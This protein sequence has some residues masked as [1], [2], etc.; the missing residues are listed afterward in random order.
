M[1]CRWHRQLCCLK[2]EVRLSATVTLS[3]SKRCVPEAEADQ[4]WSTCITFNEL[5][6]TIATPSVPLLGRAVR[7]PVCG[8]EHL[9]R[10]DRPS[11]KTVGANHDWQISII[12]RSVAVELHYTH[13]LYNSSCGLLLFLRSQGERLNDAGW[14]GEKWDCHSSLSGFI[15]T[16]N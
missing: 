11:W 10:G 9:T 14:Q 2:W 16:W 3:L 8:D 5:S 7:P 1:Y 4:F 12:A 13:R 6:C 15:Q